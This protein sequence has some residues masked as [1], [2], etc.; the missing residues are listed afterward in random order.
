MTILSVFKDSTLISDVAELTL[1]KSVFL[2]GIVFS[3]KFFLAVVGLANFISDVKCKRVRGKRLSN[4]DRVFYFAVVGTFFIIF[5]GSALHFTYELSGNQPI[6]GVFSAVNESVWEHLKLAFW[7]ALFWMVIELFSYGKSLRNFFAAKAA[8]VYFM[9]FFIPLVF[10]VYTAVTKDSI[11][12]VDISTFVVAVVLGQ[13]LSYKVIRR[14]SSFPH[15]MGY[16]ATVA[17]ILLS[18]AFIAFTFFP[19][20]FP[21]FQDSVTGNYGISL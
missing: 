15:Y 11:F 6:V 21:I 12:P 13:L 3:K 5:L 9:A 17:I 2:N 14:K 10:Y 19:P 8:E 4:H 1:L 7:P 20:H 18:G 16:A